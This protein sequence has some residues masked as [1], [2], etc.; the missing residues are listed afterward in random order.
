MYLFI[1]TETNGLPDYNDQNFSNVRLV[2]VAWILLGNDRNNILEKRDFIVRPQG[3]II[4]KESTKIHN[5]SNDLALS[6]GKEIDKVLKELSAAI[7]RSKY[8]IGH[9]LEFDLGVINNE[10]KINKSVSGISEKHLVCT[11][12]KSTE[13]VGAYNSKG[14]KWPSL[15]ELYLK[16]FNKP[17]NESHNASKDIEATS[18]CFW[19]LIDNKIIALDKI[20]IDLNQQYDQNNSNL[21]SKNLTKRIISKENMEKKLL[22]IKLKSYCES[23]KDGDS[24]SKRQIE[25]L[26]EMVDDLV[27][28]LNSEEDE[29]DDFPSFNSSS[30]SNRTPLPPMIEDGDDLPF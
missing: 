14:L 23:L 15:S 18:K 5:I 29:E 16:I 20:N 3:F 30:S 22:A 9:N 2:Q 1:D 28:I 11:M 7:R 8:V 12:K 19:W 13:F 26:F 24:V 10:F 6:A 4:S 17:F 21:I 25:K 27:E